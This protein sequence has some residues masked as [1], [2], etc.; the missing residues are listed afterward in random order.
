[1]K[2]PAS[3]NPIEDA[4]RSISVLQ[5]SGTEVVVGATKRFSDELQL[6]ATHS[7]QLRVVEKSRQIGATHARELAQKLMRSPHNGGRGHG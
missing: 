6:G 5:Q 1:M 7:P 3:L 4:I 2:K